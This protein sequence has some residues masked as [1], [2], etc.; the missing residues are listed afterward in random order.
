MLNAGD[1]E[2]GEDG[3]LMGGAR[4]ENEGIYIGLWSRGG[5]SVVFLS[6]FLSRW[7]W[8]IFWPCGIGRDGTDA[9]TLELAQSTEHIRFWNSPPIGPNHFSGCTRSSISC[10]GGYPDR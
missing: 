5:H 2:F 3:G 6:F 10:P 7:G 4:R 8:S 9:M 1:A